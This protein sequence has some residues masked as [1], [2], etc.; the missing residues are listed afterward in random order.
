MNFMTIMTQEEI[1]IETDNL[2]AYC[3]RLNE[4]TGDGDSPLSLTQNVAIVRELLKRGYDPNARNA[5]GMTPLHYAEKGLA[6]RLLIKFGADVNAQDLLGNTPLHYANNI[7]VAAA[8][9]E[10]GA[11]LN[12]KNNLG[13]TPD[14]SI[15][16]TKGEDLLSFIDFM[17]NKTITD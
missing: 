3:K 8:L 7:P 15:Y 6:A 16:S 4:E 14:R 10:A 2:I 1:K 5:A 12:I 9:I 17:N 13:E 11:S